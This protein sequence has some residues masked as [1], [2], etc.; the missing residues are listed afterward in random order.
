VERELKRRAEAP[1]EVSIVKNGDFT[2]KPKGRFFG[3]WYS[4]APPAPL[5][6]GTFV[7]GGAS[8][9]IEGGEKSVAVGQYLPDLKP[10]TR[11]RLSFFLKLEN[12]RCEGKGGGAG[13]TM[14]QGFNHS[15]PERTSYTGTMDWTHAMFEFTTD[16]ETNSRVRS[17]I[18]L[19]MSARTSG[20]AWFDGVRLV[21]LKQ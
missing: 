19:R 3:G 11:Y 4:V 5:D 6:A 9:R 17:Y 18:R 2:E 12:V 13:V 16:P 21:E 10:N 15:F 14:M 20:T 7:I 1:D 8:C